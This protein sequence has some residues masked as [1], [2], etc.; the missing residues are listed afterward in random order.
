MEENA[1]GLIHRELRRFVKPGM[2]LIDA[3]VGNGR[4]TEFLGEL[5]KEGV[6]HGYDIQK[7]ALERGRSRL[8]KFTGITFI[9]HLKSHH[10][11]MEDLR[12]A[13]LVVFNLGY[14]PGGDKSLTTMEET[15]VK[16]ME[17]ALQI[18]KVGGLL[19]VA[20]YPGHEEGMR[21]KEGLLRF[22]ESLNQK[23][24]NVLYSSFIN[25]RGNPPVV[26]FVEVKKK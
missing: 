23:S 18:L 26:F 11:M 13:D 14:L 3:T 25:Q 4:D 17:A 24:Y 22:M 9:P 21:E 20:C 5:L 10:R 1:L 6:I 12:E 19:A 2:T 15:T 16:A 8:E 7:I